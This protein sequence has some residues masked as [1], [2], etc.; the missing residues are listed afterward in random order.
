MV[1]KSETGCRNGENDAG[2]DGIGYYFAPR[3]VRLALDLISDQLRDIPNLIL[4]LRRYPDKVKAAAEAL[5][6]PMVKMGTMS[7]K[8]GAGVFYPTAFERAFSPKQYNEFYW[9]TLK[10][11]IL[12]LVEAGMKVQVF[13]EGWHDASPGDNP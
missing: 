7:I 9:P 2:L 3:G 1:W 8:A 5:V 11:V 4:D 10:E 6:E 13:F 12:K